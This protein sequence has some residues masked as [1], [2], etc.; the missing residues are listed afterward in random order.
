MVRGRITILMVM[1]IKGIGQVIKLMDMGFWMELKIIM[2]DNG[3]MGYLM[4][5]VLINLMILLNIKA[6]FIM[7]NHMVEENS[8]I[9]SCVTKDLL[10]KGCLKDKE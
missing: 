8:L 7:V 4:A 9:K 10:F 5:R 2:K 3:K 6:N 1:F